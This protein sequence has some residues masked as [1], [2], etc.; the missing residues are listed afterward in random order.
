MAATGETKELLDGIQARFGMIPGTHRGMAVNPAVLKAWVELTGALG[1][2]LDGELNE[3]IAIAIAEE[4]GCG[5]CLAADTAA[6]R[7]IGSTR[8]SSRAAARVSRRIRR[9][10]RRS[11][12]PRR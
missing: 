6:G 2:T 7:A 11:S 4:N 3:R 8:T 5:Y 10:P 12:S 9:S 1:P